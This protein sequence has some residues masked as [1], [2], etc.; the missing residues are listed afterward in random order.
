MSLS[1]QI[2]QSM[3]VNL[4]AQF[5]QGAFNNLTLVLLKEHLKDKDSAYFDGL[6]N[7]WESDFKETIDRQLVPMLQQFDDEDLASELNQLAISTVE[8]TKQ[9]FL[10]EINKG[11]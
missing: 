9:M 5:V 10:D 11:E 4:Q 3:L 8:Q 1:D 2:P 6:L 7:Q